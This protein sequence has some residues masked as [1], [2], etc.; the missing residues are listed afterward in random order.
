MYAILRFNLRQMLSSTG[1]F[2]LAAVPLSLPPESNLR[3]LWWL[4]APGFAMAGFGNL[5][6]D[7]RGALLAFASWCG[8][9]VALTL[10]GLAFVVVLLG[11]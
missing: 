6:G 10:F 1:W 2:A 5:L 8:F 3:A 11:L 9:V 4:A 7:W